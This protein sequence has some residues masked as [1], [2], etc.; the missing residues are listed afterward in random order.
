MV[1]EGGAVAETASCPS[2]GSHFPA[3]LAAKVGSY[4]EK[5]ICAMSAEVNG[6]NSVPLALEESPT[7]SFHIFPHTDWKSDYQTDPG[8][9]LLVW[10]L[11]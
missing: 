1:P 2:A 7:L 6:S 9:F 8:Y 5:V 10:I 3:S 4:V 11:V